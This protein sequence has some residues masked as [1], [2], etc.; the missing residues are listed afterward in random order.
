MSKVVNTLFTLALVLSFS[1]IYAS[2]PNP[3]LN[4]FSSLI[5]E[6][7]TDGVSCE[8]GTETEECLR[9]A[10]QAAHLDY[11]YGQKAPPSH[12]HP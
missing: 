4:T 5:G 1:L 2:R 6:V 10:T 9:R 7:E 12:H 8:E 11:I 3:S